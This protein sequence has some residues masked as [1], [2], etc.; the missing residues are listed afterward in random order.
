[1]GR[2]T[3]YTADEWPNAIG[4]ADNTATDKEADHKWY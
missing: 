4:D 1:M 3:T 2:Y